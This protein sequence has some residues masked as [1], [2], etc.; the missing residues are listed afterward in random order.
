M[1]NFILNIFLNNMKRIALAT[2]TVLVARGMI[3]TN[4][5]PGRARED[6]CPAYRRRPP[7]PT[8]EQPTVIKIIDHNIL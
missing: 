2:T 1:L 8:L 5:D 7:Q 3:P 6:L 4:Y